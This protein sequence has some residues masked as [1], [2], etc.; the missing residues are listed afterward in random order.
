[1]FLTAEETCID[2]LSM[3]RRVVVIP[4]DWIILRKLYSQENGSK[5]KKNKILKNPLITNST[6]R[7]FLPCDIN[8]K[9][10]FF[11]WVY[12][13]LE[14]LSRFRFGKKIPTPYY[15]LSVRDHTI[16][17]RL[18][19]FTDPYA[20]SLALTTKCLPKTSWNTLNN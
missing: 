7:E 5:K 16:V 14:P 9:P 1:M 2:I 12:M 4:I 3:F 6:S 17:L 19:K 18:E 13:T 11:I 15:P 10:F 20:I 8:R